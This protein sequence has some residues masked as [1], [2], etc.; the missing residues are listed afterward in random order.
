MLAGWG[1][2]PQVESKYCPVL[3]NFA[4]SDLPGASCAMTRRVS[5]IHGVSRAPRRGRS[6]GFKRMG[7]WP[8]RG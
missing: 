6:E 1:A 8:D 2:A 3:K 5:E 4:D 7:W